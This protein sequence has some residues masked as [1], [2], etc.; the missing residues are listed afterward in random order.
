M[1]TCKDEPLAHRNPRTHNMS[2]PLHFCLYIIPVYG[3]NMVSMSPIQSPNQSLR[4]N[5]LLLLLLFQSHNGP[6]WCTF[7]TLKIQD[8]IHAPNELISAQDSGTWA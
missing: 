8:G 7:S 4:K 2:S 1:F 6:M 5:I 3:S